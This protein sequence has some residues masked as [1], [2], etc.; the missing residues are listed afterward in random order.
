MSRYIARNGRVVARGTL[1]AGHHGVLRLK[2]A[3]L[4]KGKHRLVA[5]YAGSAGVHPSTSA[6]KKVRLS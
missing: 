5:Q 4:G 6:E 1:S 2:V 3:K